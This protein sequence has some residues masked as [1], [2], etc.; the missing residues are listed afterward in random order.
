MG[1]LR[2]PL[3]RSERGRKGVGSGAAEAAVDEGLQGLVLDAPG[4]GNEVEVLLEE[5]FVA[6]QTRA[7]FSFALFFRKPMILP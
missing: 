2:A 7:E 4:F 1:S 6:C 3:K 5:G